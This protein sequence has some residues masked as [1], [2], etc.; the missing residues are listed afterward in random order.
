MK[1]EDEDDVCVD[2]VTMENNCNA[3][4]LLFTLFYIT[5]FIYLKFLILL[6]VT[7]TEMLR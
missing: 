5:Y 2:G 6:I 7:E 3:Q 4:S 1:I